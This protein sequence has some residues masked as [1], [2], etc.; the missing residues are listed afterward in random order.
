M[1]FSNY[2]LLRENILEILKPDEL[3]DIAQELYNI[4]FNEDM[5]SPVKA[6]LYSVCG[7]G[8]KVIFEWEKLANINLS[9]GD[10][11]SYLNCS[12]KIINS[13]ENSHQ[14]GSRKNLKIQNFHL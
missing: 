13:L 4:A 14:A 10:F 12:G 9:M 6:Y 2:T 8:E 11:P 5:P 7:D 1:Y 3:Q